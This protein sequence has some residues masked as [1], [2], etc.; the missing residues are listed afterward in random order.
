MTLHPQQRLPQIAYSYL[1]RV[2]LMA[3]DMLSSS[4]TNGQHHATLENVE[5]AVTA[6][7]QSGC[8]PHKLIVGIPAYARHETAP[9]RVLTFAEVFDS[10]AADIDSTMLDSHDGYRWDAPHAIREKVKYARDHGLGGVFFWELGQD[11]QH[12]E[13]GPG[14]ILLEAASK[15]LKELLLQSSDEEENTEL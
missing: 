5:K 4:Q 9:E 7:L 13:L 6:V 14:G 10:V 11:K 1:D 3:Y 8:P 15:Y 12:D 2:H